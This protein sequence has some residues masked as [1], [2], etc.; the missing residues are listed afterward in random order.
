MVDYYKDTPYPETSCYCESC[1]DQP[2]FTNPNR[3]DG[4]SNSSG[5]NDTNGFKCANHMHI[6]TD[7]QPVLIPKGPNY[8][9]LNK[10]F[11]LTEATY[12][13]KIKETPCKGEGYVSSDPRL[14][15][16]GS[17]EYLSINKP[18]YESHTTPKEVYT[19]KITNYGKNY[20]NYACINAGQIQYY[21]DNELENPLFNP[22]FIIRSTVDSEIFKTPMDSYWYQFK[23]QPI[24][25]DRR[26]ISDYQN[27]RDEMSFREDIMSSYSNNM[28]KNNYG[29]TWKGVDTSK[30]K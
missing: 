16:A 4:L 13:Q 27:D 15:H 30:C 8:T 7:L 5:I 2:V 18:P 19:K 22:N 20:D 6:D 9:I 1:T 10:D 14:F 11:G 25:T 23:R 3:N 21:I 24:T 17:G 29:M 12:F 28:N 26:E